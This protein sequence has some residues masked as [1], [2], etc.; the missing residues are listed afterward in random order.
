D[1]LARR[2][3]RDRVP[4][5]GT[6]TTNGDEAPSAL[7]GGPSME[8]RRARLADGAEQL[9][10]ARGA[11][12]L[13]ARERIL[14]TIAACLMTAGIVA[15][16]IGWL[17]AAHGLLVEEQVPYLISGGLL[18]VALSL[19]GSVTLLA[20]WLTVMIRENRE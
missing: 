2:R 10:G 3:Q 5:G 18:G 15:I 4:T 13:L 6:M 7:S 12:G 14:L 11:R 19:I 20:H 8:V 16:I 1:R 9:A 17:G